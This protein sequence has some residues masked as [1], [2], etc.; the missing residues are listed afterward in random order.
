MNVVIRSVDVT[1]LGDMGSGLT[2]NLGPA[3]PDFTA[4][5]M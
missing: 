4:D 3:G 5:K 2:K 1:D